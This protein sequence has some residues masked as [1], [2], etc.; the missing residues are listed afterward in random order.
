MER[1]EKLELE[2][3]VWLGEDGY[4]TFVNGDALSG[5]VFAHFDLPLQESFY[6]LGR[7]R[8]T[9]EVLDDAPPPSG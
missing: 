3:E 7:M 1:R 8:V 4:P 9:L 5:F 2:G 6:R